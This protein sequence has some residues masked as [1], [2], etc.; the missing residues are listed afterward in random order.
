[1]NTVCYSL[2]YLYCAI[3]AKDSQQFLYYDSVLYSEDEHLVAPSFPHVLHHIFL[4]LITQTGL[5]E[6][7]F[8]CY[9]ISVMNKYSQNFVLNFCSS[10]RVR[11]QVLQNS[12]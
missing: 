7:P 5:Y 11:D 3:F 1:M 10:I 12:G 8:P 4:D 9:A 6:A 2:V